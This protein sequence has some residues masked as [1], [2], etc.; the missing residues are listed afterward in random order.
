M[1][2]FDIGEWWFQFF[3]RKKARLPGSFWML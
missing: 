1:V 2:G 3:L